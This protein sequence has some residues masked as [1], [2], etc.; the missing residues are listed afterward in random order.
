MRFRVKMTI[1]MVWLLTL[2]CGLCGTL[3]IMRSFSD[4]IQREQSSAEESYRTTAHAVQLVGTVGLRRDHA[5]VSAA[6]ER[7]R[8]SAAWCALYL[9]QDGETVYECGSVR[10]PQTALAEESGRCIVQRFSAE[11]RQYLQLSGKMGEMTLEAVFDLSAPY[12]ARTQALQFYRRCVLA[13]LPAGGLL[14]WLLSYLLTRP[15]GRV[16]NAAR[17]LAKGELSARVRVTSHDEIGRLSEDF[18]RMAGHLQENVTELR[19]AMQRQER[20]MGSFAHELK[21]PMTSIIGY[22][23]LLRTQSLDEAE[24]MCAANYIFSEGKRLEALSLKLLELQ[25]MQ[26]QA[27]KRTKTDVDALISGLVQHLRPVYAQAHVRLQCRCAA[28][29][30]MLDAD[31]VSSL[32]MNLLD[33]ARK[34]MENGGNLYIVSDTEGDFCRIRVLDNG[35]GMPAE[36][37]EHVTEAFYRVDKS[38]SR[39]QGGVGLG[40]SLCSRIVQLHGGDMK[41]DSRVGNGTCVTVRLKGKCV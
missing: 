37:L 40:L 26:H 10:A 28:G 38:R 19:E 5:A 36:A 24:A 41:F 27:L 2:A 21:T 3:L 31:L 39:A 1:G 12:E 18:N 33:N 14:A 22:A 16:S 29:V 11:G 13:V 30:W 25:V 34:A 8:G 15:L 35:C 6:L 17:R 4:A 9:S 7:L 20:F 23:D 32:L